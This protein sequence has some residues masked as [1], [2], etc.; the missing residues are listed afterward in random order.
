MILTITVIVK[1]TGDDI[2][3]FNYLFAAYWG[4][5][6]P[7]ELDIFDGSYILENGKEIIM[8]IHMRLNDLKQSIYKKVIV[9]SKGK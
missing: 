2:A 8:D 9:L 4:K 5:P 6:I 1:F 7:P 3:L